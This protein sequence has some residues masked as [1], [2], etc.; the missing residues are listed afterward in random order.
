MADNDDTSQYI[1]D[2]S[3]NS[4]SVCTY[5]ALAVFLVVI[6]IISPVSRFFIFSFIGKL[7][8]LALLGFAFYQN[9]VNIASLSKGSGMT[10]FEWTWDDVKTTI[11][12][13]SILSLF[14]LLFALFIF[15]QLFFS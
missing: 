3:N 14:I 13:S 9:G 4:M 7:G 15:R 5:L 11:I 6:F 1:R 2:F 12:L 10:F 8:I